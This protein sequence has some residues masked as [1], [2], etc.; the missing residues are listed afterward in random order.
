[1]K[2]IWKPCSTSRILDR[3]QEWIQGQNDGLWRNCE[4]HKNFSKKWYFLKKKI[5]SR[6]HL[7]TIQASKIDFFDRRIDFYQI[8]DSLYFWCL[9]KFFNFRWKK[10]EPE[11]ERTGTGANW[12][13]PKPNRTEPNRTL[14]MLHW[15]KSNT[16][17]AAV[18]I[19][20]SQQTE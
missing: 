5:W 11:P 3:L 9:S 6:D 19:K 2:T 14:G 12:S 17:A 20:R 13:R 8:L 7:G 16:C 10:R 1:M 18:K 4:F 15:A